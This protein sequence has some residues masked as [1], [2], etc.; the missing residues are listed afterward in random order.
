MKRRTPS[1]T[2]NNDRGDNVGLTAGSDSRLFIYLLFNFLH[3]ADQERRAP[4]RGDFDLAIIAEAIAIAAID[5]RMREPQFRKD[6]EKMSTVVGIEGQRGVNALSIAASTGLPRETTRR[7]IKRLVELGVIVEVTRGKYVMTPGYLQ[8]PA[9]QGT[10]ENI[11]RETL[12][13]INECLD[14]GLLKLTP[15]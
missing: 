9:L 3:R 10:L 1:P 2:S 5:P 7:K 14:Q 8:T 12:R 4:L 6:Y 15:Q 11:T 13:F